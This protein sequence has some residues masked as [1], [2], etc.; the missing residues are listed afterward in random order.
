MRALVQ[1]RWVAIAVLLG[2]AFALLSWHHILVPPRA[3]RMVRCDAQQAEFMFSLSVQLPDE[4]RPST[5]TSYA[6]RYRKGDWIAPKNYLSATDVL[7]THTT[8]WTEFGNTDITFTI[9][10]VPGPD[11]MNPYQLVIQ[12]RFGKSLAGATD[13][14]KYEIAWTDLISVRK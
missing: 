8:L 6:K 12:D 3:A 13:G 14:A 1:R 9:S 11:R 4:S 2:A 7:G 5:L 10:E